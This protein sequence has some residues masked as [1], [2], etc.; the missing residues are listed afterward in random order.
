[1]AHFK[2]G[3]KVVLSKK[4]VVVIDKF[5]G[6]GSQADIYKAHLLGTDTPV[7]FKHFYAE[8]ISRVRLK[9]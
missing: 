8:H 6:N 3:S 9:H 7:A 1:M 5:I 2:E 4:T